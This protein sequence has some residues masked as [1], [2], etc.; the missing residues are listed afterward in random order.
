MALNVILPMVMLSF[1]NT[2]V[3][4]IPV[5]SGEKISYGSYPFIKDYESNNDYVPRTFKAQK[6]F[7]HSSLESVTLKLIVNIY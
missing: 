6:I 1:L 5:E 2:L 4:L 7:L 3:F